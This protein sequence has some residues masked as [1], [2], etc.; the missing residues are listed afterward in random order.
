MHS[1]SHQIVGADQVSAHS[2]VDLCMLWRMRL[3]LHVL[4]GTNRAVS[5]VLSAQNYLKHKTF[6]FFFSHTLLLYP[7]PSPLHP[8]PLTPSPFTSPPLSH[9][10]TPNFLPLHPYTLYLSTPLP[11]LTFCLSTPTPYTALPQAL[12]ELICNVQAMEDAVIAME[13]DTKKAP[14]GESD[15]QQSSTESYVSPS[16]PPS[17]SLPPPSLLFHMYSRRQADSGSDSLGLHSP[18]ED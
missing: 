13:Y 4:W 12:I 3:V 18:Q 16:L 14:L 17:S 7:L 2:K 1:Y 8:S 15:P 10:Y 9:P 6:V 5:S 11:S